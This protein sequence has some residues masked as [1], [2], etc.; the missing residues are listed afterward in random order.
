[1]CRM[2]LQLQPRSV[3]VL[4]DAQRP[5][6]SSRPW[7]QQHHLNYRLRL[8]QDHPYP[9]NPR[10]RPT[11]AVRNTPATIHPTKLSPPIAQ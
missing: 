11:H 10:S 7:H 6:V 1:M 9:I 5:C 3:Y 2:S 4:R 8:P